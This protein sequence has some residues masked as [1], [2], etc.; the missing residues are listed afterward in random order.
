MSVRDAFDLRLLD[1][2][3]LEVLGRFQAQPQMGRGME[4]RQDGVWD[5]RQNALG[6]HV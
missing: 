5:H 2:S 4:R 3:M 1:L 6:G